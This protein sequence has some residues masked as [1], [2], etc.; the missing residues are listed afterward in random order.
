MAC[1]VY[2][3]ESFNIVGAAFAVHEALGPGFEE[4]V[5]QQAL[6][7]ELKARN[8][9]FEREKRFQLSYRGVTLD[10][11]YI[12]D[13]VCYDKIIVEIKALTEMPLVCKAQVI[14][15]LKA[16]DY[17]LGLLLNF[18]TTSL[19]HKRLLHPSLHHQL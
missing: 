16:S 15:Y 6:E 5:Y 2:K 18:G 10:K 17:Q 11:Y 1:V 14:S 9:P 13:F 19:E 8:I 3:Q 12:A 4:K 7:L